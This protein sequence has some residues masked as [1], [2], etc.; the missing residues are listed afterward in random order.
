MRV[1]MLKVAHRMRWQCPIVTIL[2]SAIGPI[3]LR[4]P[5]IPPNQITTDQQAKNELKTT[6]DE[7]KKGLNAFKKMIELLNIP[8]LSTF[9]QNFEKELAKIEKQVS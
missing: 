5:P 9:V 7:A 1:E 2:K 3:A 4:Q 6:L 8:E